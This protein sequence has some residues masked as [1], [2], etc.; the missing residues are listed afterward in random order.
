MPEEG[1]NPF[2]DDR[3]RTSSDSDGVEACHTGLEKVITNPFGD[4]SPDGDQETETLG[5]PFGFKSEEE[6]A[7]CFTERQPKRDVNPFDDS[8]DESASDSPVEDL[9]G[10]DREELESR[11]LSGYAAP[12]PLVTGNP[13]SVDRREDA[14]GYA[15]FEECG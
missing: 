6:A 14:G 4:C 15:A 10:G 8:P 7:H 1:Y 5:N 11:H 3:V 12:A 13:F 2:E 9:G